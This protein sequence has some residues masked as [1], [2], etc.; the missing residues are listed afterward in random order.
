MT[1]QQIWINVNSSFYSPG[2]W[3]N[4]KRQRWSF[5]VRKSNSLAFFAFFIFYIF[6][7]PAIN[8][9][10]R[11]NTPLNTTLLTQKHTTSYS[12]VR[13]SLSESGLTEKQTALMEITGAA[14]LTNHTH[15]STDTHTCKGLPPLRVRRR[16]FST[17]LLW[18]TDA[19][20]VAAGRWGTPDVV[21]LNDTLF[22]GVC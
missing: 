18:T 10:T 19:H 3:S 6:F 7:L 9:H 14:W 12:A 15:T 8:M 22:W 2:S 21:W 17:G 20:V 4:T 5:T 16:C 13:S 1:G 11:A